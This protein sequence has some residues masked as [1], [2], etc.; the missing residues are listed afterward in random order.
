M[1]SIWKHSEN[2]WCHIC[3]YRRKETA[4]VFYPDNA[5]HDK[6]NTKYIRVCTDCA[7]NILEV[8]DEWNEIE[9][10]PWH[11]SSRNRSNVQGDSRAVAR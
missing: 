11:K 8:C 5:E 9:T 2:D 7:R 1:A 6:I 10:T 4:D 3:G